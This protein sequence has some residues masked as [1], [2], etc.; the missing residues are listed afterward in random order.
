MLKRNFALTA[1]TTACLMLVLAAV[2]CQESAPT[3]PPPTIN[4]AFSSTTA[5]TTQVAMQL[6]FR[7]APAPTGTGRPN[8]EEVKTFSRSCLVCHNQTD[9]HSMHVTAVRLACVDC[10][11][12][13]HDVDV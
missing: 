13:H 6:G 11:G 12:G 4:T 1:I 10:H 5:P 7:F 2:S 9:S 8:D 3:T